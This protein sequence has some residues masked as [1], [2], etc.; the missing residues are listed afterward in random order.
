MERACIPLSMPNIGKAELAYVTEAVKATWVS[1]AGPDIAAFER[2]FAEYLHVDSACAVQSGTAAIHLCL[3]HFG[4]GEGDVVLVP[5]LTFIA[6]INPVIY[7]NAEPIFFDCDDHLC[8]NVRQ[9]EDYLKA[10]CTFD[11]TKTIDCKT[12][13]RVAAIIPVH[14]FGEYADMDGIM[15]LAEKYRLIV[16]EDSTEALGTRDSKGRFAGTI[17]HAGAFSFNGNKIMT[18][19]GGGMIVCKDKNSLEHM[20]YLSQQA[21]DD[22]VYFVN[23]EVGYNYRLTN[24]QA[25]LGRA[26]LSRMGDF[27]EAKRKNLALYEKLLLSSSYA[28]FKFKDWA[29]SNC[30]FYS[31]VTGDATGKVRDEMIK[32]L[33]A[34]KIQSRPI[35]KLNHLQVP[36]RNYRAKPTPNAEFWYGQIVNLPCSTNLSED[37]VRYV[38]GKV[39]E[40]EKGGLCDRQYS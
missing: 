2:E 3:R 7:Q 17:G 34:Q 20:R 18:T 14:I 1:S 30:W 40:F 29:T 16:I 13:K 38:C 39:T 37:D 36:F 28:I 5:T 24:M 12:G 26:Q 21:K 15:R 27:I 19:G 25:A 22:L 32:F 8:I 33:S 6:T 31:L 9:V 10:E 4:I 35:W 11:G 23:N